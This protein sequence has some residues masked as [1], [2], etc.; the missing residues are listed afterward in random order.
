ML[1]TYALSSAKKF[2][3]LPSE[4]KDELDTILQ[5]HQGKYLGI[6]FE[7]LLKCDNSAEKAL[8]AYAIKTD[9]NLQGY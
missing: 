5:A 7:V 6:D 1:K 3:Q 2:Y 9:L 8:L 4:T